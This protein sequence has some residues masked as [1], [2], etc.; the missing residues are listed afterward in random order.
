ML[1]SFRGQ[2]PYSTPI[3]GRSACTNPSSTNCCNILAPELAGILVLRGR[4]YFGAAPNPSR[5][6]RL[7]QLSL[8]WTWKVL[9]I[10][11]NGC[12]VMPEV[13]WRWVGGT[14]SQLDLDIADDSQP[15]HLFGACAS[16]E[17][18]PTKAETTAIYTHTLA[19]TR[20][21]VN[22][23]A[24]HLH[25]AVLVLVCRKLGLPVPVGVQLAVD[26]GH[27][28]IVAKQQVT[29][30]QPHCSPGCPQEWV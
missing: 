13:S 22:T 21:H 12:T 10:F 14:M 20:V 11:H 23:E 1:R 27:A 16:I 2:L 26:E 30:K 28:T 9:R 5:Q 29:S 7:Q 8:V 19:D 4:G 15:Q 17:M 18:M 24:N 25:I 3:A 6:H